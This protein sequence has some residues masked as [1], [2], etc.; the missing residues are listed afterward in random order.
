MSFS[1]TFHLTLVVVFRV[2]IL[3]L[4]FV[5]YIYSNRMWALTGHG[6]QSCWWSAEPEKCFFPCPRSRLRV[7]RAR[8]VRP[9]SPAP[10]R[11]SSTPKLFTGYSSFLRFPRGRPSIPSSAIIEGQSP[12]NQVT[13]LG[14][15]GVHRR[16]S[17]GTRPLA[18]KLTRVTVAVYS[19]SPVDQSGMCTP[20]FPHPLLN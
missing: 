2:F 3:L 1:P 10:A 11:S 4:F 13:H 6:C 8:Q 17:A 7:C 19:R 18:L 5:H 20:L 9:F 12:A 15:D 16:E 14:T